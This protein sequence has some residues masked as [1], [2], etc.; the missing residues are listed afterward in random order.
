MRTS[1][2]KD[3]LMGSVPVSGRVRIR[4]QVLLS[5]EF[6]PYALHLSP[7]AS[8]QSQFL[9]CDT[10]QHDVR[11]VDCEASLPVQEPVT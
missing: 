2:N 7:K 9:S 10:R 4:T 11:G 5:L 1:L 8:T 6:T 3:V